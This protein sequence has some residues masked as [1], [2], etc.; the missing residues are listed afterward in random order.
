MIQ[1]YADNVLVYDSRLAEY[2]LQS[3]TL[4]RGLNVGGTAV[5]TMPPHH[6]AYDAF[7]AFRTIVEVYKDGV[8]RFRGRALPPADDFY[9]MRTVTCEGERCFFQDALQDNS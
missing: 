2:A 9:N 3:L 4:S 7:V 8:L 6:P 1:I 5:I